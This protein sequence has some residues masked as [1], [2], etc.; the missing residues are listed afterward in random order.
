MKNTKKNKILNI[1]F[2]AM[3]H[4]DVHVEF[5]S[6]P[7]KAL[8]KYPETKNVEYG[9]DTQGI[10]IHCKDESRSFIFLPFHV[11]AGTIAHEAWHV[12]RRMMDYLGIEL[13]NEAVAYHLGY[14]VNKI[15]EGQRR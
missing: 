3:G 13:D 12:I 4:Y 15:A 7:Q 8:L 11:S 6:N 5:S 2:A 10:A 9:K 1:Q 14:L